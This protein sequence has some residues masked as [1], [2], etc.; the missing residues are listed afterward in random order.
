MGDNPGPRFGIIIVLLEVN[1][2][3]VNRLFFLIALSTITLHI[4]A[5]NPLVMNWFNYQVKSRF[6]TSFKG[7]YSSK[8][9]SPR[10]IS[11]R[12]IHHGLTNSIALSTVRYG[13]QNIIMI[14]GISCV[15]YSPFSFNKYRFRRLYHQATQTVQNTNVRKSTDYQSLTPQQAYRKAQQLMQECMLTFDEKNPFSY[16]IDEVLKIAELYPEEICTQ[17]NIDNIEELQDGLREV[18]ETK[19]T[20]EVI[21][22]LWMYWGLLPDTVRS[23]SKVRLYWNLSKRLSY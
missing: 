22:T 5:I 18:R 13:N 20:R 10:I 16:Y 12:F 3:M 9:F 11:N 1:M 7:S 4:H 21:N 19:N 23:T 17:L 15:K 8:L 2:K 14:P 6:S